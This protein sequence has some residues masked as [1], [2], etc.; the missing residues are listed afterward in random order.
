MLICLFVDDL[1]LVSNKQRHI[2]DFIKTLIEDG[3]KYNWEHTREGDLAEF[4]GIELHRSDD[5]KSFQLLQKGLINMILKIIDTDGTLEPRTLQCAAMESL[6]QRTKT[7]CPSTTIG[8]IEVSS[9]R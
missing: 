4:L 8:R 9:D 7:E 1:V 5:R 6:L 3:D 2:D